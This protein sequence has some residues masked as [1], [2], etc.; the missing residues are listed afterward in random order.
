MPLTI[1]FIQTSNING[2]YELSLH[3][4]EERLA[5]GL[6][7]SALEQALQSA[8]LIEDYPNDPRG[9]SCLILGFA[10]GRAIHVVCGLT[11][12]QNLILI[13]VYLPALPKWRDERTRAREN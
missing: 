2:Q 1:E 10:E 13:T 7:V 11:R 12:Q 8:E 5:E 3:A 6:T 4:D 9:H